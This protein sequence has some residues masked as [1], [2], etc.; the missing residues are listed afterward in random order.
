MTTPTPVAASTATPVEAALPETS[1]AGAPGL[2]AQ[3]G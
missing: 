1:L 3:A 2:L